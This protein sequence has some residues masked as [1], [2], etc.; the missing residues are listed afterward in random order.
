MKKKLLILTMLPLLALTSC[1]RG[2]KI[3]EEKA[4]EIANAIHDYN[5]D[6]ANNAFK[7]FD[8]VVSMDGYSGEGTNKKKQS[9]KYKLQVNNREDDRDDVRFE[10]KGTDGENNLDFLYMDLKVE[11]YEKNVSYLKAYNEETK[12]YDEMA[13]TDGSSN[14]TITSYSLQMLLPALMLAKFVDPVVLMQKQKEN[15]EHEMSFNT[16][17]LFGYDSE[18]EAEK[19]EEKWEFYSKGD[20]NLTI[21][22]SNEYKGT[23]KFEEEDMVKS[24]F[25]ITY[26]KFIIKSAKMTA[27]SNL[28]NDVKYTINVSA[29]KEEIK[30]E[31]PSGWEKKVVPSSSIPVASSEP[32]SS[33]IA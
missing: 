31:L 23:E 28:G 26:N 14:K 33:A 18:E 25:E 16:D 32:T 6:D 7:S 10:G 20:G 11:G 30:L 15:D 9:L 21:V 5:E 17:Y 8:M 19:Y 22:A 12:K 3:E 24:S 1:G 13:I 4:K 2:A 29:K 27:K